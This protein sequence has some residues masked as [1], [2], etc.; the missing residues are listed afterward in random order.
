MTEQTGPEPPVRHGRYT[1]TTTH[2]GWGA[3][4]PR[5]LVTSEDDR[6]V[7]EIAHDLTRIGSAA[8]VELVLPAADP[9]HATIA[10]DA[11]DE[12][13]LTMFGAG[14][15]NALTHRE[16][17]SGRSE[18]LRTGAHFTT[19]PWR[20]V[21]ARDEFADHGRPY[22]GRQGGEGAHQRR[23]PA[24]PD[25]A[26]QHPATPQASDSSPHPATSEDEA[27]ALGRAVLSDAAEDA[28]RAP[29][30][31]VRVV[32]DRNARVYEAI[33]GDAAAGGVTYN[34]VGDDRLV[35]LAVSV[36]PEFRGRGIA[37]DLIRQVLDDVRA[38]G[39]T[40]TNFCPVVRTFI[41]RNPGYADLVD[42][43][44]PGVLTG[45]LRSQTPDDLA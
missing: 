30:P 33:V 24:R 7:H 19:G 35:L 1:P 32:N 16:D 22:G 39:R 11:T 3:G 14:E 41:E 40:V 34:L 2:A 13:V 17:G 27:R 5:L 37:A 21:F 29:E 6:Y 45:R 15:T 26:K 10:H 8:D 4:R 44:H 42:A 43:A 23:Q 36:F 31:G 20:L 38:Q 9:L 25:Y 12:Y 28:P 18:V